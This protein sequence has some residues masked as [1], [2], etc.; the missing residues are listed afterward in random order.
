MADS[1]HTVSSALHSLGKLTSVLNK[2]K[3]SNRF[4]KFNAIND[5]SVLYCYDCRF[6]VLSTKPS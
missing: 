3:M 1:S 5:A 6:G 4:L 2:M